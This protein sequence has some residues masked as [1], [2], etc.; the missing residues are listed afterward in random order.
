MTTTTSAARIAANR[1]NA[2]KSTGP[3]T[4]EGKAKAR[5]NALKHGMR[6]DTL[7]LPGADAEAFQQRLDDWTDAYAG[8]DPARALV[9]ARAVHASWRLER[10][11]N[12]EAARLARN[13]RHAA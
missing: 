2:Q 8:D 11:A 1:L 13:V 3:K 6:A 7:V 4:P 9:V 12:A 5:F 10:C